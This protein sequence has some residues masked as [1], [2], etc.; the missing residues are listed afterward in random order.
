MKNPSVSATWSLSFYLRNFFRQHYGGMRVPPGPRGV[1]Q[2][3][4]VVA[5]MTTADTVYMN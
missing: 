1:L 5:A 2:G 4:Q 3:A